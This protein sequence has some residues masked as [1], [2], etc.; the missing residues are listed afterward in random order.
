MSHRPSSVLLRSQSL[1]ALDAVG[2]PTTLLLD[3]NGRETGRIVGPAEWD[4][5]VTVEFLG[6]IVS[7]RNESLA[8]APGS[9]DTSTPP[10][11]GAL[12]ALLH[13]LQWLKALF[14]K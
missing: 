1:R 4:K 5:P 6:Q 12:G 7:K 8:V 9:Q 3:R 13:G 10:E 11:R 2:L 14:A